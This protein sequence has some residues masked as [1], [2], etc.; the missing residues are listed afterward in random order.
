MSAET[1][2]EWTRRVPFEACFNFRDLGGYSGIDGR[3]VRWG[4]LFRADTLHRLT[5]TDVEALGRLGL[6]TVLDLRSES[7]IADFGRLRDEARDR[8][9]WH[10]LPMIDLVILRPRAD[11]EPAP[12]PRDPNEPPGSSYV[13]MVGDGT[14]LARAVG[15]LAAP[16]H[17]PAVFHCTAGKDRTGIVAAA[18][19]DLLGVADEAI[20]EDYVETET[21]R[22]RSMAWIREHEPTFGAFMDQF[23]AERRVTRPEVIAG[24]LAA[25]R[26]AHGSVEQLLVSR[27]LPSE[28]LDRLRDQLLEP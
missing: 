19:L 20:V 8:L 4:R 23:P 27:G 2:T 24:F 5:D 18:T 1:A 16:E 26:A 28:A 12:P 25:V 9:T 14:M 15:L 7:E 3:T 22:E 21:S 6:Q 10:H 17:L 13:R 11:D